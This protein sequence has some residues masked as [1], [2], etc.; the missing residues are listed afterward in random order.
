MAVKIK[1]AK[2]P[3]ILYTICTQY[4]PEPWLIIVGPFKEDINNLTT[5]G[6]TKIMHNIGPKVFGSGS[7]V[8]IIIDDENFSCMKHMSRQ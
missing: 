3:H 2:R 8:Y 5:K 1:A 6:R 7:T 4:K